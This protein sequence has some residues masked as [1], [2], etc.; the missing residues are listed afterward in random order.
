MYFYDYFNK[1]NFINIKNMFGMKA[2]FGILFLLLA[3]VCGPFADAQL[4]TARIFNNGMVLQCE[5]D[6]PVWGTA[7]AGDT[8]VV[9]LNGVSDTAIADEAGKWEAKLAAMSAGGP[10]TMTIISGNTTLTRT[11]VYLGD[12]WLASGQSNMEFKLS[13]SEGGTAEIAVA[14]NQTI[15]QFLVQNT[16]GDEPAED[17]PSN[18]AWTAAIAATVGN[19]TAVGYYFA[20]YLQQDIGIPVG[21]INASKGGARIETFMSEEMLGYDEKDIT[22][23][24]GEAERQPTVAYNTMIHPLLRA[25]IKGIIW[26]QAESNGD[27][28]EDALS[29]GHLFKKLINSYRELW[30]LGDIP[31]IWVQLPNQGAAATESA[32]NAWDAWPKL[33]EAQSKALV[34][35]NTGEATT[36]DVGDVDI[37]P[38][39]KE[40]VGKRLSLVARKVAYGEDLV[41]S[42]PRYKGHI[43]PGDGS[44]KIGFDHVGGGLVAKNSIGDSIHWF[45]MAGSNGTLYKADAV[46]AGD[47]VV[48]KCAQVPEPAII[49]YAWE[50]NPV[51]INFYNAE[52]LPAV[53]FYIFAVNPGFGIRSFA[54]TAT[55]I[56]R[57]KS[58]V[59]S[60]E[61][62]GASSVTLNGEPVDS[63]DG[64][65]VLP[66][67]TAVYILRA[68]NRN[69]EAETD[70]ATLTIDVIEPRPTILL[71]SDVGDMVAPGTEITFTAELTI[72]EGLTIEKVEFYID[73]AL[74]FTDTEAPYEVTW[75]PLGAGEYA[76][77]AVVTDAN[78]K[79]V[80]SNTIDLV[81]TNL[82]VLTFEAE[83]ATRTGS[84]SVKS[85]TKASGG[86][87]VDL[88]DAWT[89]TFS[90]IHVPETKEY[91]LS[92]RYLLNYESPKTQNLK[93]NGVLFTSIEFTAANTNTWMTYRLDVPLAA[94]DNEIMIE[95][96]WNWMSF[97]YISIAGE[98]LVSIRDIE[99]DRNSGLMLSDNFPNPFSRSTR[100]DYFLPQTGHVLLEVFDVNGRRVAS[101]VNEEQMAGTH[102][103]QFVAGKDIYCGVYVAKLSFNQNTLTRRMVIK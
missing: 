38:V 86:K 59:L 5:M 24:N 69:N 98:G 72:P 85:S 60:W 91:Q 103:C 47:S 2:R 40:P 32:P 46:I 61:V 71:K 19:F 76:V 83:N 54:S 73:D 17:V 50:Y 96:V 64:L 56:E 58:A 62:Y 68:V 43:L 28:M 67:D 63:I 102:S 57:G 36:M 4:Q 15:R 6:I 34:L 14:N 13:Q 100:I 35:P 81:V 77:K 74:L 31:F 78:E 10:Y 23:A 52:D 3:G 97:D 16:L 41:Y 33:R 79:M 30:G 51:N 21:I 65:R 88:T 20:K 55:V 94:G 27:N 8:V 90:G 53:P 89:L 39:K 84:G 25:P 92:I 45:S 9:S 12:V 99:P 18:S 70:S 80:E 44:V 101:L 82:T 37:H 22:L 95:G 29:Y 66:R 1:V 26:Y 75:T 42:G 11:D 48:V 87:Y 93:I 7:G 49:R